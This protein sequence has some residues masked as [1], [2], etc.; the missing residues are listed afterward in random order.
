MEGDWGW[1]IAIDLF[2]GGLG[3]GACMIAVF[4]EFSGLREKCGSHCPVSLIGATVPG[5]FLIV[6]IFTPIS[7]LS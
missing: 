5:V 1:F 2:L 6:G 4:Y 7:L 3:A